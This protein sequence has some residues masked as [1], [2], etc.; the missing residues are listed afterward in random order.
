MVKKSEIFSTSSQTSLLQDPTVTCVQKSFFF[1]NLVLVL[2]M[3]VSECFW[4]KHS[5]KPLGVKIVNVKILLIVSISTRMIFYGDT[6]FAPSL[7]VRTNQCQLLHKNIKFK[8]L[9]FSLC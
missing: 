1:Q 4:W 5:L 2:G 7:I 3:A 6:H 8:N 9:N